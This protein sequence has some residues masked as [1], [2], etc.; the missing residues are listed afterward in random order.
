[1]LILSFVLLI[2]LSLSSGNEFA[3]AG[4]DN[5]TLNAQIF[6]GVFET[7]LDH[8]RPQ[9]FVKVKFVSMIH[10]IIIPSYLKP[11]SVD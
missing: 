11:S 4:T 10:T 8:F 7:R 6:N 5:S 1:M 9:Y 3:G 2:T